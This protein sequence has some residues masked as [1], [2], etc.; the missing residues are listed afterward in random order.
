MSDPDV[1]ELFL[2]AVTKQDEIPPTVCSEPILSK[3]SWQRLFF[4]IDSG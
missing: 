1:R 3:D 4:V 2:R